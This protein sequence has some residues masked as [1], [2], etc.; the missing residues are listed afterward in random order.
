MNS[1]KSLELRS[2][3]ALVIFGLVACSEQVATE[4]A[5]S[6]NPSH[7]FDTKDYCQQ[8]GAA[9]GGSSQVEATC[10]ELEKTAQGNIAR[11]SVLPSITKHCEEV[12]QVSGGSYQI[13]ETC[14]LKELSSKSK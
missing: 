11:M 7:S 3:L 14:I 12:G 2:I 13:M 4:T 1:P 8:V 9:V 6:A 10:L 5:T